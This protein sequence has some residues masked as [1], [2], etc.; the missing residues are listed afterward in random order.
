VPDTDE[1]S[2]IGCPGSLL[3]SSSAFCVLSLR[4]N[5]KSELNP[6][7]D[8]N[9]ALELPGESISGDLEAYPESKDEMDRLLASLKRARFVA[10]E[11]SK[12]PS[13]I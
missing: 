7:D 4:P 2:L 8:L 13:D 1:A 12:D 11:G 5:L 3:L 6:K 9:P 10:G